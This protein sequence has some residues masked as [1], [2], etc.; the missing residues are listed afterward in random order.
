MPDGE[1]TMAEPLYF[2]THVFCCNNTRPPGHKRGCCAEKGSEK[3]R[4]YM[5]VRVKELGLPEMRI[6]SAGC[7]DRCELGPVMVVY[8][9]GIWYNYRTR[10]DV[11]EIVE[12]HLKNGQPVERLRLQLNQK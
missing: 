3:L 6:N 2:R 12:S 8:P 7:L 10:E 5:K 11:D 9:E 4:D 1:M